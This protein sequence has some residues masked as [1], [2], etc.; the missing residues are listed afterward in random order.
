MNLWEKILDA[1]FAITK[2]PSFSITVP[3]ER[4]GYIKVK[5]SLKLLDAIHLAYNHPE[6]APSPGV[7]H[8]NQFVNEVCAYLGFRDLDG[9]MANEIVDLLE[10]HPEWSKMELERCQ[11]LANGGSLI[12]AGIKEEGHGHVNVICPGKPKMSG[13]WGGDVPSCANVGKENFIGKGINWAFATAPV[14]YVWRQTL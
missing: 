5:D 8:C 3:I 1:T 10:T 2:N 11:D 12:I 13:K 14:F 6:Y 7:T 4:T 9:K